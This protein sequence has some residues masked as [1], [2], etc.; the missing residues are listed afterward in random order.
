VFSS[1]PYFAKALMEIS[2]SIKPGSDSYVTVS[3]DESPFAIEPNPG[4]STVK[5]PNKFESQGRDGFSRD[6]EESPGAR[7]GNQPWTKSISVQEV[8]VLIRDNMVFFIE[9]V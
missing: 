7:I 6:I 8:P 4:Q 3:V 9:L 5:R 1:E 2:H